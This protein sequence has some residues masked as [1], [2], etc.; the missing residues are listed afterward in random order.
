MLLVRAERDDRARMAAALPGPVQREDRARRHIRRGHTPAAQ[1]APSPRPGCWQAKARLPRHGSAART[2]RRPWR[3][4]PMCESRGVA[5]QKPRPIPARNSFRCPMWS[6]EGTTGNSQGRQPLETGHSCIRSPGGAI[7]FTV[8]P[9]GLTDLLGSLSC[10]T[11]L[12]GYDLPSSTFPR[13]VLGGANPAHLP[14]F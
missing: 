9:L 13:E 4:Q 1:Q 12:R 10:L 5:A 14:N 3:L 8:A 2:P 11:P 6:P 7:E